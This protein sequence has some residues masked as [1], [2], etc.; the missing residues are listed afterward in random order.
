M[1]NRLYLQGDPPASTT[2]EKPKEAATVILVRQALENSWEIFLARRH[3]RQS[4]M[5]GAFV[6][7]GGRLEERDGDP[8]FCRFLADDFRPQ[9][10]LRDTSLTAEAARRFF[11]AAIRE[12]FEEAGILLAGE[13]NGSFIPLQQQ[14]VIDR[15]SGYRRDLNNN[16]ISFL[17][18]LS[19][20]KLVL[21]PD[22]L[23]P[24]S[25]WITPRIEA[26]R[27]DTR[28]FLA[29]LPQGQ[30]AVSDCAELT[31]ILW[32]SPRNAL[33]MHFSGKISLMPPTLKTVTELAQFS[34]IEELIS[35]AKSRI[36]YPILPQVFARGVKLPHD[37]EY[38]IERYKR[39]AN[40]SEPSR[41]IMED[42][43]WKAVCPND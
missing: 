1:Q 23:I 28:F 29:V 36:I 26:K 20:E 37:P 30:E 6:F 15:F 24:Y 9:E 21:F 27:F 19:R 32:V 35:A 42:G 38:S 11:I 25:H 40:P 13:V 10:A 43:I 14:E 4:F 22:T 2:G 17:E 34:S 5:A 7:P 12:T 33:Q 39:L 3:H 41:I 8:E 16:Q 18:M 31:E